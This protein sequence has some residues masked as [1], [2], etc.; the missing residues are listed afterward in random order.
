M[1]ICEAPIGK[2]GND[3]RNELR[4]AEC[5]KQRR[6]RAFH[7]EEAVRA[8]DE[9]E[10]LRDDGDLQVHYHM[11]LRV[12]VVLGLARAS[13]QVHLELPLEECRLENDNDKR[14]A[15]QGVA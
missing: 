15:I 1:D 4:K 11:Q 7:K 10:R 12:V 2:T 6:R 14:N 5:N 13:R 8:S 9:D 3:R